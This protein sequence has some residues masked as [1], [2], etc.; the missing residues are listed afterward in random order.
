M[1]I[2]SIH[3]GLPGFFKHAGS[4]IKLLRQFMSQKLFI[5]FLSIATVKSPMKMKLSEVLLS[6]SMTRFKHSR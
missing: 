2:R 3:V 5:E 6:L 1:S 4:L